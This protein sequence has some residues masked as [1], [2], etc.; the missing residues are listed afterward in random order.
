LPTDPEWWAS[1]LVWLLIRRLGE[2]VDRKQPR[3]AVIDWFDDWL[4]WREIERQAR[5]LGLGSTE[6]EAVIDN[7]RLL[8]A[9]DGWWATDG[10]EAIDVSGVMSVLVSHDPGR[11]FLGVNSWDGELWYR[12]EALDELVEWL[13]VSA[14]LDTWKDVETTAEIGGAL[15]RLVEAGEAS[16][17]RVAELLT[18]LEDR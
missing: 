7:I 18:A 4:L 5:E 11:T 12:A 15:N 17:Y 1:V 10:D 6:A 8:L 2:V 14:V 16:G 13:K 3:L 9:V